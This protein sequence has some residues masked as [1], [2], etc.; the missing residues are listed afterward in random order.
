MTDDTDQPTVAAPAARTKIATLYAWIATNSDGAETICSY[1]RIL[2]VSH[3]RGRIESLRPFAENSRDRDG[4]PVH[5]KMFTAGVV[6]D[7]IA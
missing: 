1:G 2:L 4:R 3:D 5:L 6:I 7:T